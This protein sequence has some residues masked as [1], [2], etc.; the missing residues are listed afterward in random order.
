MKI[1]IIILA[2]FQVVTASSQQFQ[3][4][5]KS[6]KLAWTGYGE[7]G[8]FK[9]SGTIKARAGSLMLAENG[10]IQSAQVVIDMKSIHHA[11]KNLSKHLLKKDFFN[12]KKYPTAELVL[13]S[14]EDHQVTAN[15]T[16]KGITHAITF[17]IQFEKEGTRMIIK[18]AVTIDRTKYGIKYNSSSYF[19][20]LGNYAIKNEFDLSFELVFE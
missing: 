19:Q 13:L 7:I 14:I 18:G 10:T 17:P 12:S 1:L 3:L 8:D 5:P 6:S 20:D 4:N 15:L 11:D 16:I 9:Q 2:L